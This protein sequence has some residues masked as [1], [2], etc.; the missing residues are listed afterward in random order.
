M[1]GSNSANFKTSYSLTCSKLDTS[2]KLFGNTPRSEENRT[3]SEVIVDQDKESKMWITMDK[4][5]YNQ[6]LAKLI[7]NKIACLLESVNV[8][9]VLG[10]FEWSKKGALYVTIGAEVQSYTKA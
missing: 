10:N 3:S 2:K 4:N 6:I 5:K 9:M 1:E 7:A 8:A